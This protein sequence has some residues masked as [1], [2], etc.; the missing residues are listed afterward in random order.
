MIEDYIS[1]AKLLLCGVNWPLATFY[2]LFLGQNKKFIKKTRMQGGQRVK[3]L[4]QRNKEIIKAEKNN[5][6]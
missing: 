3:D 4:I 5:K 6:Y 1:T 2:F